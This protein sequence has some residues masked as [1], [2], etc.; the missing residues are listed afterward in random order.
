MKSILFVAA[1]GFIGAFARYFIANR[2]K[3]MGSLPAT[4]LVVN[5][6]GSF[7]LGLLTGALLESE[8]SLLIGTGILGSFTTFST[9]KMEITEL[10]MEKKW[11]SVALY[12]AFS[13][14]GGIFLA[15]SGYFLGTHFA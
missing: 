12:I 13:Y 8:I 2:L 6:T 15:F 10:I 11:A 9:F 5:L 1:G 7:L 3:P 14:I 4:T